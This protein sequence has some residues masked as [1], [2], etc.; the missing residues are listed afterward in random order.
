MQQTI[1]IL[2]TLVGIGV[3]TSLAVYQLRRTISI[4]RARL[5]HD[6]EMLELANKLNLPTGNLH[7]RL[8]EELEI[9]VENETALQARSPLSDPQFIGMSIYGLVVLI[10]FSVWT[11]YLV[12]DGFTW[13]ALLT[14]VF[15]LG[16]LMQPVVAWEEV[17][18]RKKQNGSPPNP[19]NQA[20]EKTHTAE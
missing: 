19:S 20:D 13:W 12:R 18:R 3:T 2:V 10:G 7:E 5:K 4:R 11:L 8:A 6:L 14:G 15:A 1:E 9:F 17:N 16:G